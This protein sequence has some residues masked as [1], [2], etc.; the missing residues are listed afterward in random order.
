MHDSH[1]PLNNLKN[2]L[3]RRF[4]NTENEPWNI[5]WICY[6]FANDR[7]Y[8]GVIDYLK[9]GYPINNHNKAALL[10]GESNVLTLSPELLLHVEF[11]ILADIDYRMILH[12]KHLIDCIN[13]A[14]T[15]ETFLNFYKENFPAEIIKYDDNGDII[16][17]NEKILQKKLTEELGEVFFLSPKRFKQCKEAVKKLNFAVINIDLSDTISC[18]KLK[19]LL[20]EVN[21]EITI[22]NLT[23]IHEY[24]KH[25]SIA[26][27]LEI[28]TKDST[29]FLVMHSDCIAGYSPAAQINRGLERYFF[30]LELDSQNSKELDRSILNIS[31]PIT[32]KWQ[33]IKFENCKNYEIKSYYRG[34]DTLSS[35]INNELNT[36]KRNLLSVSQ[37]Q[38]INM[39]DKNPEEDSKT[40]N[41]IPS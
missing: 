25:D 29:E 19:S 31:L 2:A 35:A 36:R 20:Q 24:A 12:I 1:E 41:K 15:P 21:I 14:E 6:L 22:F 8:K 17:F 9:G 37:Q 38:E 33:V 10:F 39:A 30:S 3:E 16:S 32:D 28:I 34:N 40:E 26:K 5:R 11:V 13:N 23:N 18:A 4:P 7:E 27:S